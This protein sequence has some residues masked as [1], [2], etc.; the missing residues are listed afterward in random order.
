MI[1]TSKLAREFFREDLEA[2]RSRGPE[3]YTLRRIGQVG[4]R[5]P[6]GTHR[7]AEIADSATVSSWSMKLVSERRGKLV[8]RSDQQV[9]IT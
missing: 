6:G 9:L 3:D 7:P 8:R 2:A 5:H 4:G 1:T